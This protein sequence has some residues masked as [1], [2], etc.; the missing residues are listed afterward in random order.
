MGKTKF[1]IGCLIQWFECDI[2]EEYISTIQ[3]AIKD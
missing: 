2:N 1:A 3:D